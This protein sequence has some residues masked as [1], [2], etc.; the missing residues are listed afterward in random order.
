M[1][2]THAYALEGARRALARVT[3]ATEAHAHSHAAAEASMWLAALDEELGGKD[4]RSPYVAACRD[5]EVRDLL[6][7]IR[8]VRNQATHALAR[9]ASDNGRIPFALPTP[10][11]APRLV[12]EGTQAPEGQRPAQRKAYMSALVGRDVVD[13]L[14]TAIDWLSQHLAVDEDRT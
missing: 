14:G 1:H 6:Q 9:L 3:A 11:S 5:D 12:W 4:D 13:T 7:G 10:L 8:Y 2:A